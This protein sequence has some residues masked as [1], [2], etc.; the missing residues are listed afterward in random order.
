HEA[1]EVP[2]RRAGARATTPRSLAGTERGERALCPMAHLPI[3]VLVAIRLAQ[4]ADQ[5]GDAGAGARAELAERVEGIAGHRN[6]LVEELEQGRY[7]GLADLDEAPERLVPALVAPAV[8]PGHDRVL[9]RLVSPV[10]EGLPADELVAVASDEGRVK[11]ID[12]PAGHPAV[13]SGKRGRERAAAQNTPIRC[14]VSSARWAANGPASRTSRATPARSC[15]SA[16]TAG[17]SDCPRRPRGTRAAPDSG[18][19]GQTIHET[20]GS[21]PRQP[22]LTIGCAPSRTQNTEPWRRALHVV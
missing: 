18:G 10:A 20:L 17:S 4:D 8:P 7:G 6:A 1:R 2:R 12:E 14:A 15:G 5:R 3:G 19:R 16:D 9:A 13:G 21:F 11:A 22:R